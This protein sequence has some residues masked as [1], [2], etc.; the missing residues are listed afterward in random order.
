VLGICSFRHLFIYKQVTSHSM[1]T[2]QGMD[3]FSNFLTG[4]D[5]GEYCVPI[6]QYYGRTK[7]AI[8]DPVFLR[9]VHKST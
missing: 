4:K 8:Q 1:S 2:V 3:H 7:G 9:L 6:H 5:Q